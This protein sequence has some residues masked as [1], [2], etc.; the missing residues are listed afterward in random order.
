MTGCSRRGF[1]G[2]LAAL[3]IVAKLGMAKEV[4]LTETA[5]NVTPEMVEAVMNEP[6]DSDAFKHM[7]CGGSGVMPMCSG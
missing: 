7:L 2:A 4:Q 6:L 1:L 3:P 5:P